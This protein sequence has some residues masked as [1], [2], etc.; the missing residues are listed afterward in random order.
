MN[1]Y[2]IA[3]GLRNKKDSL[4]IFGINNINNNDNN[5]QLEKVN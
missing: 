4:A 3:E 1:I 5:D 2:G